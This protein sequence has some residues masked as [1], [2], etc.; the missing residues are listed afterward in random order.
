MGGRTLGIIGRLLL[1]AAVLVVGYEVYRALD[2]GSYDV[3]TPSELWSRLSPDSLD[4]VHAR[5]PTLWD[6]FLDPIIRLPLWLLLLL[7]GLF[8]EYRHYVRQARLPPPTG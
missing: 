6:N 5:H 8:L 1:L 4:V 3:I 7:P 2:R